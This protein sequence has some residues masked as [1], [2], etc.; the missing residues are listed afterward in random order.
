MKIKVT[1]KD[2]DVLSDAI[3]EAV[4]AEVKAMNLPKDETELLI[5]ARMNKHSAAMGKWWEYSEYLTV[6]FDMDSM[7]AHVVEL[8]AGR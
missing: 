6:E 2:P 3:T 7:T 1:I 8:G 5:E 4:E